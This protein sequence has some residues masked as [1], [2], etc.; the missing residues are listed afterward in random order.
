MDN[1]T[2][3]TDGD[4]THFIMLTVTSG[5][6]MCMFSLLPTRSLNKYNGISY[7]GFFHDSLFN[8]SWVDI[9]VFGLL[10]IGFVL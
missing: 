3:T 8:V 7:S 10:S 1:P 5:V 6:L 9:L 4:H 2:I